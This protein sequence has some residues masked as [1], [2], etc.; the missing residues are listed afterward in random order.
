MNQKRR[1]FFKLLAYSIAGATVAPAVLRQGL[2][3]ADSSSSPSVEDIAKLLYIDPTTLEYKIISYC[4]NYCTNLYIVSHYQPIYMVEVSRGGD[5]S[6][7]T[8]KSGETKSGMLSHKSGYKSFTVRLWSIPDWAIDIAMA[9]QS[10]KLCGKDY[11]P[12]SDTDSQ[13]S[14]DSGGSI[15]SSS[16]CFSS[17]WMQEALSA[18]NDSLGDCFPSLLYY[19]SL[20]YDWRFGCYKDILRVD[21]IKS[22]ACASEDDNSIISGISETL[23]GDKEDYCVGSWGPIYPRQMAWQYADAR[24]GAA[25]SA[26]RALH[27]AGEKD[28]LDYS[29]SV[30]LGK[31]QLTHPHQRPGYLVGTKDGRKSITKKDVSKTDQFVFIWW[32]PV[33]CCKTQ[34]EIQGIC[35]PSVSCT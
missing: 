32:L 15:I 23:Y 4:C 31:L 17:E 11:A 24:M 13:S 3:F 19:S 26:Y 30:D 12:T 22:A 20:D 25:L 34:S 33:G 9:Y 14:G 16:A 28:M 29:V 6:V 5:D 7:I 8:G 18:I 2:A 1:N 27:L 21:P 10:C 35:S